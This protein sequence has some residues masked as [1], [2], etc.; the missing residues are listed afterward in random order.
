MD[1]EGTQYVRALGKL[2]LGSLAVTERQSRPAQRE[3][4]VPLQHPVTA[5]D[6]R[7]ER[8][9]LLGDHIQPVDGRRTGRDAVFD[10]RFQNTQ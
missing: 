1:A 6:R 3:V 10:N 2:L 7:R 5:P 8:Q 9:L 4:A